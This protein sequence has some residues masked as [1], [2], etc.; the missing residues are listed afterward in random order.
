MI[1]RNIYIM[2]AISLLQGMV[3]YAPV[4][5][6]YR[7]ARGLSVFHI[8]LIESL[9]FVVMILLE[10]PWGYVADKIGYKKVMTICCFLYFISKLVFLRADGFIWF[11]SERILLGV[12]CAGLSGVDSAMLY[13]STDKENSQKVFGVYS[14]LSRA[15]LL[16][17]AG[18]FALFIKDDFWLSA[19]AT[20]ISYL[21][22]AILSLFLKEVKLKEKE[23]EKT[24]I[25]YAFATLKQTF[26]NSK[27]LLL[28]L[29][30]ALFSQT[31]QTLTVFLNQPKYVATGLDTTMISV[32]YIFVTL[33][34]V[35][36]AFSYLFTKKIGTKNFGII[37]LTSAIFS[38]GGI[39]FSGSGFLC[40]VFMVVLAIS[41][42][43]FEP[44]QI[45]IQNTEIKSENR[46]TVL[47]INS[48]L[49]SLLAVFTNVIFGKT[50]DVNI[51]YAFLLGAGFCAAG[52]VLYI[53]SFL[54]RKI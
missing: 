49:M 7:Q 39:A 13:E 28:V 34:G 15:G 6:L 24:S 45:Q 8:T 33:S 47:S 50:A 51:N 5:T 10:I 21:S 2:Y 38:C 40:I 12:V 35:C 46:A 29:S 20:T 9:S 32:A 23:R 14:A 16:I 18:A 52:L 11:L 44:V 1:K 31:C 54:K 22:A 27:L 17:A 43:M 41:W 30:T 42:S 36:S 4:A 26:A 53:L 37:L 19:F 48:A 25:K 3:F